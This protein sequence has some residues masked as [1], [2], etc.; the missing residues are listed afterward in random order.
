[1]PT[2]D[3]Q[4][5][6]VYDEFNRKQKIKTHLQHLHIIIAQKEQ[7]LAKL[8]A[9]LDEEQAD[10][11]ALEGKNLY[12]IFQYLLGNK[13]EQLEKAKQEYLAAYVKYNALTSNL[14]GLREER[15][16]LEKSYSSLHAI[17]EQFEQ[18]IK[19]KMALL[20]QRRKLPAGFDKLTE[21]IANY[22]SKIRELQQTIKKGISAKKYLHKVMLGLQ[23]IEHW[24]DVPPLE[25][26]D[27]IDRKVERINKDI[28][29]ANNY[30][31]KYEDELSDI[32]DLFQLDYQ[33]EV[34]QLEFFL[35]QFIDCLIT[36]W[37]V[38]QKIHNAYHLIMNIIDKI[39]RIGE[40]MDYEIDKTK[41]YIE[42][43]EQ[44]K[45]N[46]VMEQIDAKDQQAK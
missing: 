26:P 40:M 43:E 36:D 38:K 44:A 11:D 45:A 46:L 14:E 16:V 4:L 18:L 20:N 25:V 3:Q 17:D 24:G 12:S 9:I 34:N 31:Q 1:M 27:R 2:L 33:R 5:L 10:L 39:T 28:Y 42:E 19:Q 41:G 35:D 15:S 13:E 32:S 6:A 8:T 30:L 29:V 21:K 37:I 23:Q 22:H 7:A